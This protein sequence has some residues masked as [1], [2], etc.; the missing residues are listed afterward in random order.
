MDKTFKTMTTWNK[1]C[2]LDG[3]VIVV[4][5]YNYDLSFRKDYLGEINPSNFKY[6]E[7]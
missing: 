7:I 1:G 3:I 4:N 2:A 6:L 5:L